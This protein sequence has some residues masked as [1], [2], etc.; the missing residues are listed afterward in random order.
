MKEFLLKNYQWIIPLI[1]GGVLVPFIIFYFQKRAKNKMVYKPDIFVTEV[2]NQHFFNIE[3]INTGTEDIIDFQG[4]IYWQQ[5]GKKEVRRLCAFINENEN[6]LFASPR[7]CRILRKGEKKIAVNIPH[8][9]DDGKIE[10]VIKGVGAY[11]R[12]KID[13][14]FIVENKVKEK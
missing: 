4:I 6:Q 10:V 14:K 8:Y 2:W 9:S 3:F 5:E 1:I 11:S 13:K 12:E 7:N